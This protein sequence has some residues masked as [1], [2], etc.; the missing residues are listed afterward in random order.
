MKIDNYIQ[1]YTDSLKKGIESIDPVLVDKAINFLVNTTL[2]R[3]TI[4]VCGNGGSAAISEHFLCDHTK[5]IYA[6]TRF[7]PRVISLPSSISLTTAIAND[8]AFEHI[9]SYQLDMFS[10]TGD[11]LVAISSS[12]NSP[13][14]IRVLRAAKNS[15]V[16]TIALVGFDGGEALDIADV[17]LHVPISNYGI[18]EDAHQA[19]MHIMAQFIRLTFKTKENIKL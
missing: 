16:N 19:L 17:V 18:V 6:D 2:H 15:G 10:Q 13:N 1:T 11:T 5:G 14:I 3:G 4:F 12:G 9:F 8:I 7:L